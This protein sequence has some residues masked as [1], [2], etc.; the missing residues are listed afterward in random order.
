MINMDFEVVKE[1]LG[2]LG[3][4]KATVNRWPFERLPKVYEKCAAI[5]DKWVGE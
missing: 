3:P 1:L 4:R 2:Y 5:E